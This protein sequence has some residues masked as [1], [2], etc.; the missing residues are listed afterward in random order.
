[1]GWPGETLAT[2]L[3]ADAIKAEAEAIIRGLVDRVVLS[4]DPQNEKLRAEL[5]GD[6]ANILAF[7]EATPSKSKLPGPS[8]PGS[9]LPVVAGA[10]FL[11][12]PTKLELKKAV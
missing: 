7:S 1:M 3:N 9:Q 11:Q 10:G 4:P 12:A 2:S 5:Y 6:L 8:E